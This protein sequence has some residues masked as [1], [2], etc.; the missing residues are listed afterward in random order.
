[1][2]LVF[3]TGNYGFYVDCEETEFL[4]KLLEKLPLTS[5]VALWGEE[6]Y[7]DIGLEF[8]PSECT[9]EVNVGDVAY[10]PEGKAICVFLGPTPLSSSEK[11]VPANEVFVF[12]HT[13][14]SPQELKHI[15][16]GETIEVF[17]YKETSTREEQRD[18]NRILSQSEID[19]LVQRLL[20][21]KNKKG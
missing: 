13:D 5:N 6:I 11:P 21:E 20:S 7:F 12:G 1:M 3:K 8:V 16:E 9:R 15:K 14:A 19:A 17:P 10:W 18:D 4:Q 2:R